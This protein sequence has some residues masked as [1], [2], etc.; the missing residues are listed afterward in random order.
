MP[1]I[2]K[3]PPMDP[4]AIPAIFPGVRAWCV[5]VGLGLAVSFDVAAVPVS[6]MVAILIQ[7]CINFHNSWRT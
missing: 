4:I 3:A 2:I 5:D 6:G 7:S 1:P